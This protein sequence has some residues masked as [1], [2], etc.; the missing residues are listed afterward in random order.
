MLT[1][2]QMIIIGAFALAITALILGCSFED[3][4]RLL[5]ILIGVGG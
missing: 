4:A 3:V 2:K 1:N 5:P